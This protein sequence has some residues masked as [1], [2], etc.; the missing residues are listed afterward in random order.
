MIVRAVTDVAGI[1]KE[2]DYLAP[3]GAEPRIGIGTEVRLPLGGRRVG[4]WVVDLPDRAPPGVTLKPLAKVRG[5][6]PDAEIVELAGWAAWRWAGR[7]SAFL[8]AASAGHAVPQLP[9]PGA[10]R[11]P[12]RPASTPVVLPG[13]P[14]VHVIEVAPATDPTSLVAAAAQ[15]GPILVVVPTVARAAVLAGRL[16]RAGA[17]VAL[18]PG[19][20]VAARAGGAGVVVGAR[21]AAFG[22]CPGLAA[23][24]V[25]DAHDQGLVAE[26]APTWS[27]LTVAAERAARR[28]VPLYALTPA[29]TPELAG[30]GALTRQ[31][32]GSALAGWAVTEVV[33]RR[34]DDPRAGL[35]SPRLVAAV[36]SGA[37]MALVLN[38]TGRVR[39]LACAACGEL[40]RCEVC[41]AAMASPE[42][43]RLHCPRCGHERP[44]VCP[45]CRSIRV[46]NLR[47]GVGRAR[48]E[49]EAL[50]GRPVG[51]VSA[52]GTVLSDADVVVGT[53][54]L[55]HRLGPS[56][57]ISVVAFVDFDQELMAP[58]VTAPM[59]A[60]GLL[61]LASR[62]VR[63]RAGRVVIQTR[64]PDHPVVRAAV[65]AD[66][67]VALAGQD[68]LRRAL[69]FPPHASMAVVRGARAGEWVAGLAGV[70]VSGPDPSGA[71]LVRAGDIASLCDALAARPRPPGGEVR[72]AVEPARY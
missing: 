18:L 14:G 17:T 50:A 66:P 5:F 69:G 10:P 25:L 64:Q 30:L 71:W 60:L 9:A 57:G 33:D 52:A 37:R 46:A 72:V 6:G 13:G 34:L 23:V 22:P 21:T 29:P 4:G 63:G 44:T 62:I 70:R 65:A 20:W 38:R 27:A 58:R 48:E 35:W 15:L 3:A 42:P 56:A 51:E 16:R 53:E 68:E 67:L 36:R 12:Q 61:A 39:L 28:G 2:F 32:R 54:A 11:A 7:R 41:Q 59:Q 19:E 26:G 1:D 40:S 24:V 49:L 45:A 43:G 47:I 8:R 31:E 55:L